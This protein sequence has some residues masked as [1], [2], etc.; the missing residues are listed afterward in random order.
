[1]IK[2]KHKGNFSKTEKFFNRMLRR[3]YL[4]VL[5]KYGQ[6]GVKMLQQATPVDT[7]KTAASWNYEIEENKNGH[8][9]LAFTNSN[10]NEGVNVVLMLMYG[11]GLQ[12]GT[13][14]EGEDFVNPAIRPVFKDMIKNLWK[15]VNR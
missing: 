2:V 7:G 6:L 8:I 15:E 13:Y 14:I 11:H 4:N 3:D 9:V 1:M 10:N 12:D 5:S